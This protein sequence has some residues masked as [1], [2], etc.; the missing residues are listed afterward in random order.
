[1]G[2]TFI[3]YH[4]LESSAI[5]IEDH[6]RPGSTELQNLKRL[7]SIDELR[8]VH[9][10]SIRLQH[11]LEPK[12][13]AVEIICVLEETLGYEL[14]AVL[15]VDGSSD[16][17]IPFALSDQKQGP[18]FVEEDRK[19]IMSYDLRLGHGITGW[20]AAHGKTIRT[21]NVNT[22]PRYLGIRTGIM[23][24]L[25]V[26]MLVK[27]NVIGVVNVETSLPNA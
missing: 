4:P 20:V 19:T 13:L 18:Q 3:D 6:I 27:G 5:G 12:E 8:A 9:R 25:C 24:E 11:T 1:M 22:D 2:T 17:L 7:R 16:R 15:L 10:A 26:P 21:A 14:G 23:S